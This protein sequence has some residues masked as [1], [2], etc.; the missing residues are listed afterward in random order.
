MTI[1]TGPPQMYGG[2]N[3]AL[4]ASDMVKRVQVGIQDLRLHIKE[5]VTAVENGEHAVFTRRGKSVAV[6]VPIEWYRE[7]TKKMGDPTEF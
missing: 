2:S 5:R 3:I 4:Y 6:L 7:A 1:T